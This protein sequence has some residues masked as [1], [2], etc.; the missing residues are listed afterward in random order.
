MTERLIPRSPAQRRPWS[1]MRQ[2]LFNSWFNSLLTFVSLSLALWLAIAI[3][4]WTA[5]VAQW[6]AVT[7]N[8]RLYFAG[9]YPVELLWRVWASLGL[10]VTQTGLSWGI[11]TPDVSLFNRG[12]LLIFGI[13]ALIFIGLT[14]TIGTTAAVI[15]VAMLVLLLLGRSLGKNIA[16]NLPQLAKNRVFCLVNSLYPGAVVATGRRLFDPRKPR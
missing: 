14:P 13:L 10:I 2:N 9:R 7:A 1:W 4:S 11:L 8:L 6:E 3:L 5:T 15:L 16:Q 12:D